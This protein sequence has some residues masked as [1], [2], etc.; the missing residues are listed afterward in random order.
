LSS[1]ISEKS[2]KPRKPKIRCYTRQNNNKKENGEKPSSKQLSM[3]LAKENQKLP[4]QLHQQVGCNFE[5]KSKN[6][7]IKSKIDSAKKS[8]CCCI[9]FLRT[10]DISF[11]KTDRNVFLKSTS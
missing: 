1:R 7:L 4:W 3:I 9:G 8:E 10:T 11:L 5:V 6:K 2:R